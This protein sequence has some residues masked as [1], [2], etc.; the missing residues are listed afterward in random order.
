MFRILKF[1]ITGDWHLCKWEQFER[2]DVYDPDNVGGNPIYS[3]IAC[4]CTICGKLKS[5]KY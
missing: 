2:I 5:F 4:V 1:L 3:K